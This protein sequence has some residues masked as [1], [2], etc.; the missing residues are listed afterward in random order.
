MKRED[1]NKV[2][3]M[4]MKYANIRLETM[5]YELKQI[6]NGGKVNQ[7]H[8]SKLGFIGGK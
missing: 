1:E 5:R 2:T 4:N 8:R 6:A 7:L 3:S